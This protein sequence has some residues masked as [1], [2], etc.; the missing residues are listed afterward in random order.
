MK[1]FSKSRRM[2]FSFLE[3][4]LSFS[5]YLRFHV[6]QMRKV[7]TSLVVPLKQYNTQ[8]RISLEIL[9]QCSSNLAQEMYIIKERKWHLSC[10]CHDNSY[11]AG[12]ILIETKLPRF[13]L[14]Q[15]SS[16]SNNLLARVKTIWEPCV[17]RAKHS[18]LLS[19]VAYAGIWFFRERDWNQGCCHSN[20]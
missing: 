13:Y 9:K 5:K 6:M 10:C 12:P 17:F 15:G 16:T 7:T 8:S 18:V 20:K 3:Y 19:K 2:A 4:L 14:K 1:G 11:T